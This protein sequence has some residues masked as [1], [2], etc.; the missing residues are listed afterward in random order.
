MW[1]WAAGSTKPDPDELGGAG[2]LTKRADPDG[3]GT[4]VGVSLPGGSIQPP[5]IRKAQQARPGGRETQFQNEL[6]AQE[7]LPSYPGKALT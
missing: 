3:G 5:S 7:H 4:P 2:H 6:L 1:S